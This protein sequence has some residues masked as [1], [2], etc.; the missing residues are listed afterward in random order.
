VGQL[1]ILEG[2]RIQNNNIKESPETT[3]IRP[4]TVRSESRWARIKGFGSDFHEK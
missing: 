2:A 3:Y 4:N 1:V